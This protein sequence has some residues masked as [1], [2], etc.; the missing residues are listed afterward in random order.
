M[1]IRRCHTCHAAGRALKPPCSFLAHPRSTAGSCQTRRASGRQP[2]QPG[3]PGQQAGAAD[4]SKPGVQRPQQHVLGTRYSQRTG[5]YSVLATACPPATRLF[6]NKR[7]ELRRATQTRV[8]LHPRRPPAAHPRTAHML[9][10]PPPPLSVAA[11]PAR[12][13]RHRLPWLV[14]HRGTARQHQSRRRRRRCI[15]NPPSPAHALGP[16]IGALTT[17]SW[18]KADQ[19]R[20]STAPRG[21]VHLCSPTPPPPRLPATRPMRPRPH[22]S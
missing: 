18:C 8:R 3:Q 7:R 13:R 11:R 22:L 2:Q 16:R 20:T 5:T 19:P 15:A 12:F 10:H 4:R 6:A 1:H 17:R 14:Q 21:Q 9:P